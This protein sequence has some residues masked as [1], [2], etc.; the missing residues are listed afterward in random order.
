MIL[1]IDTH[2]DLTPDILLSISKQIQD[3]LTS[4]LAPYKWSIHNTIDIKEYS[5]EIDEALSDA[6]QSIREAEYK[7]ERLKE[8][9]GDLIT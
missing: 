3:W 6:R 9:I 1:K 7:F 5:D 8:S 4:W 2:L